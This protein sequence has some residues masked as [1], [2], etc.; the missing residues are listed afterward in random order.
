[1]ELWDLA[2]GIGECPEPVSFKDFCEAAD[3]FSKLIIEGG[4]PDNLIKTYWVHQILPPPDETNSSEVRSTKFLPNGTES[5]GDTTGAF[6]ESLQFI[7][8]MMREYPGRISYIECGVRNDSS[9]G[10]AGMTWNVEYKNVSLYDSEL[11]GADNPLFYDENIRAL[12]ERYTKYNIT[13][14]TYYNDFLIRVKGLYYGLDVLSREEAFTQDKEVSL[15]DWKY[16]INPIAFKNTR[17]FKELKS[18]GVSK[19]E[20]MKDYF[21]ERFRDLSDDYSRERVMLLI[22]EEA[23][24]IANGQD[25]AYEFIGMLKFGEYP[26]NENVEQM[27][28]RQDNLECRKE[29]LSIFVDIVVDML[30]KCKG[31][32]EPACENIEY[33]KS[34]EDGRDIIF[35]N[36]TGSK[37][38]VLEELNIRCNFTDPLKYYRLLP[39]EDNLSTLEEKKNYLLSLEDRE[40]VDE[41]RNLLSYMGIRYYE[42][43]TLDELLSGY[44]YS[45]TKSDK[46]LILAEELKAIALAG[47]SQAIGNNKED[48]SILLDY[49][50]KEFYE[51]CDWKRSYS[52]TSISKS[53]LKLLIAERLFSEYK[54]KKGVDELLRLLRYY[55]DNGSWGRLRESI[56]MT[57]AYLAPDDAA[58]RP[59]CSEVKNSSFWEYYYYQCTADLNDIHWEGVIQMSTYYSG[60]WN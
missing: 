11:Y 13:P 38:S 23:E 49:L 28:W 3:E 18:A 1:M 36:L 37:S 7:E 9:G 30:K 15:S 44:L 52:N 50:L 19:V 35:Y 14:C 25:T 16:Y 10:C 27:L 54:N 43:D 22:A 41:V 8:D 53:E 6:Y 5:S 12:K 46:S 26:V 34:E 33:V 47:I 55:Y 4:K 32:E 57:D 21:S 42:I 17:S 59:K 2:D 45:D 24:R 29:V 60:G 20:F 56:T 40:L 51:Y 39:G 58:G 31:F 48:D